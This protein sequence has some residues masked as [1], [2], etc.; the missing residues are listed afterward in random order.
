MAAALDVERIKA[1]LVI[2][3]TGH[4]DIRAED[5]ES[6]E[7]SV[8]DVLL[9]LRGQYGSTP[10]ILLSPLAEGADQLV[11]RVALLPEIGARLIVPLPMPQPMYEPDFSEDSLKEFNRLLALADQSFEIPLVAHEAAVSRIGPERDRQYEAVGKYIA[12]ESQILIALWDGA[13]SDKV[14]GTAAIVKFQTEGLYEQDECKLLPPE[15]FPVYHILTPRVRNPRPEGNLA[16]FQVKVIYPPAFGSDREAENY[17]ERTFGNL[18]EFNRLA[19]Q[20][21]TSLENEAAK[22]KTWVIGDFDEANFSRSEAWTLNRF[23]AADALAM[24]FQKRML[25][26]HRALHWLVF[27]SFSGFVLF[28]HLQEHPSYA[29]AVS[30]ILLAVGYF[31]HMEAKR[32]ALDAKRLD[33]RAMAEGCRAGFF[34][35][36][37][38]VKT[39]VANNY[40]GRQRTELDWIRNGLRGWDIGLDRHPPAAWADPK[41]RLQFVV[42]HWVADQHEYFKGAV[43]K[44]EKKSELMERLVKACLIAAILIGIGLF[45]ATKMIAWPPE[46]EPLWM[47]TTI[48][49]IDLFL[50]GAALLHHANERMAHSEHLKQYRR[51]VNIFDNAGK[52]IQGLLDSGNLA[53]AK[54]CVRALGQEALI[55]NGDWVLLHRER[56]LEIPHP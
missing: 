55:E 23:A 38:G 26:T 29:L 54:T 33:F 9:E 16:P 12:R 36:L 7:K 49:F 46:D 28:A 50:A 19:A 56:P 8:R 39:S 35:Q 45:I 24:Q 51:M 18:N 53:G 44:S 21:G 13:K 15:L 32:M 22:S 48:I 2:G 17:Y 5:R 3:V 25:W 20:S 41:E 40:L 34:W 30:L 37:A 6:L 10:F 31:S 42:T 11:A 43:E 52:S 27:L 1:P 4:R 14:G 47:A